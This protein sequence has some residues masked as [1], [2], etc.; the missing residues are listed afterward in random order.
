MRPVHSFRLPWPARR[1]ILALSIPRRSTMN[2]RRQGRF[3]D[4]ILMLVVLF[5]PVSLM[6]V[7]A[8]TAAAVAA[9]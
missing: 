6:M 4:E 5:V 1:R 3:L 2:T 7:G 9:A 8:M